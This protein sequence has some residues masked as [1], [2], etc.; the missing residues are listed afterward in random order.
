LRTRRDRWEFDPALASEE[1]PRRLNIA[2]LDGL[3]L[4]PADAAA[5]GAAG[6]LLRYV[7]ELQ[8]GGLPHLQRPAVRR[9]DQLCWVDEMTRR[10]LELVEP[11]RAG[12]K[13]V[14]LFEI[15]DR[16]MTPMG[17]RLLRQWVVSP[18]RD[19]DRIQARHRATGRTRRCG[20]RQPPRD[21]R[22]ARFAR[23][24]SCSC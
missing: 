7:S 17:A 21:G 1:L 19:L 9:G 22:T 12:A 18:L 20:S 2:S 14:T 15:L 23:A 11:L 5:V 16:T 13:G 4:E 8:P 10:N 3:G 6:A 24:S